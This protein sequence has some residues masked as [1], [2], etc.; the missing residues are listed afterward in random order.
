MNLRR[1]TVADFAAVVA[2]QHAAYAPNQVRLGVVPLPLQADYAEIFR[3]MQVWVADA[4]DGQGIAGV[5]ILEPHPDHMLI[6]SISTDPARQA[7]GLGHAMLRVAEDKARESGLSLMRLY[8]GTLL[9]HLVAWYGRNGY[10]V[11]RVE[12]RP[13]RSVTFMAKVLVG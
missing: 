3:S 11:E 13:D 2:L 1:A 10:T 7:K 5:L 9:T 4:A 12:T 6:W 8:T